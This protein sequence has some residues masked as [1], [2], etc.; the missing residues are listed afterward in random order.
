MLPPHRPATASTSNPVQMPSTG[1][2]GIALRT[3]EPSPRIRKDVVTTDVRVGVGRHRDKLELIRDSLRPFEQACTTDT[4]S[5]QMHCNNN[6]NAEDETRRQIMLNTLTQI[7]FEREA[8]MLALQLVRFSS[9]AAAAEVLLNINK[10]HVFQ[11]DL[12][13]LSNGVH[14]P[15]PPP[16][17]IPLG[18]SSP[19]YVNNNN[20]N[21]NL[22]YSPAKPT[23]SMLQSA[24]PAVAAGGI[25]QIVPTTSST[26]SANHDDSCSSRS[27]SPL[28]RIPSPPASI[29]VRSPSPQ[30][31]ITSNVFHQASEYHRTHAHLTLS[32]AKAVTSAYDY[33]VP[34]C[35]QAGVMPVQMPGLRTGV[36]CSRKV[37]RPHAQ[38]A[39][40]VIS[41]EKGVPGTG[42]R[43]IRPVTSINSHMNANSPVRR[44]E[45]IPVI[46]TRLERPH[47]TMLQ[48]NVDSS[49]MAGDGSR[50]NRYHL[51]AIND[52]T[53]QTVT[54]HGNPTGMTGI[55][56]ILVDPD[57]TSA[58]YANYVDQLCRRTMLMTA[59]DRDSI[60]SSN[61][62]DS[63]PLH[64]G[65]HR[66]STASVHSTRSSPPLAAAST[67]TAENDCVI[68][69]VSPLPESVA[70]RLRN[71]TYESSIK[72]CRPRLFCF[73]MEQHVERLIQQYKERQQRAQ[74]LAKEMECAD[75]PE[76]MR[77]QMMKFLTQKESRYL[78]LRRQKM[79]KNMF[80]VI[81]HIG[82]GAFGRVSLVKK[83]DTG[84]VY[85]MKTLLKKDV[86]MKQQAAHVKAERDIL[87]EANSQW[88]VKLFFSFQDQQSLYFI[89]EYVPGGDMMQLL[90]NK[91]VFYEKLARFYT[92]ELTCAI[93]YVHRLGFIHRDIKPD[94][95][96]I[97]QNGHLKLTD[98]GLCTGLRWTHDK[99]YYGP[100][101]DEVE[102]AHSRQDS[103][104]IPPHLMGKNRP[105][106]LDIRN[107]CK[108]NQSHSLVGTD[109]Y[110]APEVIRGTGHTQLCDWWS[111][112]VILYE[113]V[114]GRPPFM[115]EDRYETQFKIVNWRQ[116]L[117]LSNRMG[118]KL[119]SDCISMIRRLCCDQEN[120]LGCENGA[121]DIKQHSW[122]KGIDFATLRSTRAEYIP[123]VDHAEDTS[124]F[125]TFDVESSDQSFD[126]M[127]KRAGTATNPAFYE[128]TFRHFF[129]FDGQGCPSLRTQRRPSLAPVFESNGK[130]YQPI[131]QQHQQLSYKEPL[132]KQYSDGLD[133]DDSL[134]V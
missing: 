134:V 104:N 111:V 94:N 57:L 55:Q 122:F 65:Y 98:F 35:S 64:E 131:T 79:D 83:K 90:I 37:E 72:P 44:T 88:I 132:T 58:G 17:A 34:S 25:P 103:F 126:T 16:P 117:D 107:H 92:A 61:T 87:A 36:A 85:A 96:L 110:M 77:E 19:S 24:V 31:Q 28:A 42:E 84:Q 119:T 71:K 68:R 7:G 121:Q 53:G 86:I 23:P 14:P 52:E 128:F 99:R 1:T 97:D 69:C 78:R 18:T 81:K 5:A 3:P 93:E 56:S 80:E 116:F 43:F 89:M 39:S 20:N 73:F 123:R 82:F 118:A 8:A 60:A 114:F 51:N 49:Q 100:D 50:R 76:N 40:T 108:R 32:A 124:N 112:G 2:V 12:P 22:A 4:S 115:S 48:I 27:D 47:N 33:A 10:D 95:I 105:K 102:G 63:N 26:A 54:V 113:M 13:R 59:G 21:N 9:V 74:Q 41:I 66:T 75:L 30:R 120:R 101:N 46:R 70:R 91:G 130:S 45:A 129:D 125:D 38:Q 67:S 15:P 6:L 11:Q 106:V 29:G 62:S 127:A 109:N 133:S